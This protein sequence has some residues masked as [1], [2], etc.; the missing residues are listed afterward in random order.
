MSGTYPRRGEILQVQLPDETKR[1]PALVISVN[2]RNELSN[3]VLVVPLTTNLKPSPTHVM[4]PAGQGGLRHASMARCENLG[5]LR[6][7]RLNRAAFSGAVSAVLLR[8]IEVAI[9]R[10]LGMTPSTASTAHP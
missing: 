9:S 5:Y 6:N 10:A 2:P 7:D 8:E 3:S 4:L 1:R